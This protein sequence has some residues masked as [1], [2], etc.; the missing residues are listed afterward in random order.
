M[1]QPQLVQVALDAQGHTTVGVDRDGGSLALRSWLHSRR[2][3]SAVERGHGAPGVR[4]SAQ[5]LRRTRL[6][7]HLLPDRGQP[8]HDTAMNRLPTAPT[9]RPQ[10]AGLNE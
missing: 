9:T 2:G 8:N 6:T 10:A 1:P 7:L 3:I 4:P 5:R